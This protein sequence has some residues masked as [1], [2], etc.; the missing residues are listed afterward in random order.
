MK[1]LLKC[2]CLILV[3][4]VVSVF[5]LTGCK[6]KNNNTPPTKYMSSENAGKVINSAF[7]ALYGDTIPEVPPQY[8]DPVNPE[9]EAPEDDEPGPN[10][11][12][13]PGPLPE[14]EPGP[15][16]E[17]E[18]APQAESTS[19]RAASG[20]NEIA[21][22]TSSSIYE[23][24]ASKAQN[25][26]TTDGTVATTTLGMLDLSLV[27]KYPLTIARSLVALEK[28]EAFSKTMTYSYAFAEDI[29][30]DQLDCKIKITAYNNSILIECHTIYADEEFESFFIDIVFD[31]TYSATKIIYCLSNESGNNSDYF[32]FAVYDINN[33][34]V[35]SMKYELE[36]VSSDI[37]ALKS[38]VRNFKE[39]T[40]TEDDS[41][42]LYSIY[43]LLNTF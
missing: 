42:S 28:L 36:T 38:A 35:S 14:P 20:S 18:P 16:P 31:S 39:S 4:P 10:P 1:K 33:D 37:T 40:G 5:A 34:T 23:T 2:L 3:V 19:A 26:S 15:L 6:D 24:A 22:N 43:K 13:D 25:F 29:Y 27:L 9:E 30:P 12:P 21:I 32:C 8:E 11:S 17:P 41:V 7:V